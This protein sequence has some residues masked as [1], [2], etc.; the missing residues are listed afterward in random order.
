MGLVLQ[1][2]GMKK[3]K[4]FSCSFPDGQ[5]GPLNVLRVGA[6][7]GVRP[8]GCLRWSAHPLG[9]TVFGDPRQYPAFAPNTLGMAVGILVFCI[10]LLIIYPK[11]VCTPLILVCYS[12]F[13]FC[14]LR[15]LSRCKHCS[16]RFKVPTCL[17]YGN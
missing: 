6:G 7:P 3:S 17:S 9:G 5:A 12:F 8:E 13:A 1:Q 4:N 10:L 16:K 2:Q 11:Q 14:C 15:H